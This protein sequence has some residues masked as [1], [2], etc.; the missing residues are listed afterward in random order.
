MRV[1]RSSIWRTMKR[2]S[3]RWFMGGCLQRGGA[4]V[5][6]GAWDHSWREPR[7]NRAVHGGHGGGADLPRRT[8]ATILRS[9]AILLVQSAVAPPPPA[10]VADPRSDQPARDDGAQTAELGGATR[11][12][13]LRRLVDRG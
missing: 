7:M 6:G 4:D 5:A 12:S 2:S 8:A 11:R 9:D 1:G 3:R 13:W 10:P